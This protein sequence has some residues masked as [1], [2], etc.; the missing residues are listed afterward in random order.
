MILGFTDAIVAGSILFGGLRAAGRKGNAFKAFAH[1]YVGFMFGLGLGM[2]R[3]HDDDCKVVL[4][5]A[6]LLSLV[7]CV[8]FLITRA[9]PWGWPDGGERGLGAMAL[10]DDYERLLHDYERIKA[11]GKA[12]R[13]AQKE[14]YD[15]ARKTGSSLSKAKAAERDYDRLVGELDGPGGLFDYRHGGKSDVS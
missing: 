15:P 7:E 14:F 10:R 6:T 3:R 12:M 9:I 11:A 1:L 13:E 4:I 2:F 5:F 8:M